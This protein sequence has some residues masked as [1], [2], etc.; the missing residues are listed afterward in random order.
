MFDNIDITA[1]DKERNKKKPVERDW[2]AAV[3][4]S[5]QANPHIA[6]SSLT[7]LT[8]PSIKIR[9]L[10]GIRQKRIIKIKRKIIEFEAAVSQNERYCSAAPDLLAMNGTSS[11]PFGRR[12]RSYRSFN[13]LPSSSLKMHKRL[14]MFGRSSFFLCYP[15]KRLTKLNAP[16]HQTKSRHCAEAAEELCVN[17]NHQNSYRT[18]WLRLQHPTC[19]VWHVNWIW[20]EKNGQNWKIRT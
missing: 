15:P 1:V 5:I 12:F 7:R 3:D 9:E 11:E 4:S 6:I 13:A 10:R 18:V 16:N 19:H 8:S 2:C 14:P 20:W 17:C